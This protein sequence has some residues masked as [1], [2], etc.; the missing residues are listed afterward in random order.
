MNRSKVS[1]I[2]ESIKL[3]F[4]K[5]KYYFNIYNNVLDLILGVVIKH[6]RYA[7]ILIEDTLSLL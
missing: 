5:F 1:Q 2:L 6:I 4:G 7:K 3:F